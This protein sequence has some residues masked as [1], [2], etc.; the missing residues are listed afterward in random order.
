[1]EPAVTVRT[2]QDTKKILCSAVGLGALTV[3]V[4]TLVFFLLYWNRFLGM[5]S[6]DGEYS[7]GAAFLAGL[8]PYRDYFSAAPPLSVLKSAAVLSVFG[9]ALITL[10]AFAVFE[11]VLLALTLFFWLCRLFRPSFAA[12]GAAVTIVLSAGD[13]SDPLCSYNHDTILLAMLS[14]F[15][16]SFALDEGRSLRALAPIAAMAGVFAGLSFATKQTIG[17]GACVVTPI[18]VSAVLLRLDGMRRAAVWG[19]GFLLGLGVATGGLMLWL[20]HLG[21]VHAFVNMVFVKGPAAKSSHPID[22]LTRIVQVMRSPRRIVVLSVVTVLAVWRSLRRSSLKAPKVSSLGE[23][24]SNHET[25]SILWILAGGVGTLAAGALISYFSILHVHIQYG[26]AV[27]LF[28]ELALIVL[29]V[30]YALR[31]F[32]GALTRR[33]AQFALLAA[34]SFVVAFMLSLSY[35]AFEA[36]LIPGLGFLIAAPLDGLRPRL[37]P[38]IYV[39]AALLVIFYTR[40]RLDTPFGFDQFPEPSV[41]TAHS[42]STLPQLRGLELPQS[43]VDFVDGTVKI[44]RTHSTPQDTIFTYPE[45]GIFYTLSERRYPTLSGSHNMD[46]VSDQFAR[47]EAQRLLFAPPAVI[48]YRHESEEKLHTDELLWRHGHRSGQR[49]LI[50]AV[51]SLVKDYWL[52]ASYNLGDSSNPVL[53]YVRQ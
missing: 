4:L 35:P 2:S 53:V 49:D 19:G 5:R 12:I 11:R 44:I 51:E 36:M 41:W 8:R 40:A 52:A 25:K 32:F 42:T 43:T 15:I 33:R 27:I 39:T 20:A 31:C 21:I 16:A 48:I 50:A 22:F 37:R 26:K 10:R 28:A 18:V 9:N 30:E 7:G 45:L 38:L 13:G 24:D 34:V 46:V 23:S 17:L 47:E 6:G 3:V 14:G 1:M 29:L